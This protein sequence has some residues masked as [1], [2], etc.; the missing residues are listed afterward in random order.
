MQALE[1]ALKTA[2]AQI[3]EAEATARIRN[4]YFEI[5]VSNAPTLFGVFSEQGKSSLLSQALADRNTDSSM[6]HRGLIVQVNAIFESFIRAVCESVLAA[7]TEKASSFVEMDDTFR[8][9]YIHHSAVILTHA[10]EGAV[11]GRS[12]DFER[13]QTTLAGCILGK[14]GYEVRTEVF[15]MLMGNCTSDRLARLFRKLNLTDPFDDRVGDHAGLRKCANERSRRKAAKFARKTL[16]E[17]V[18]LRNEIAHGSLTKAVSFSELEFSA[19]FFREY[20]QAVT[21]STMLDLK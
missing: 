15:T 18:R 9:E 6:L 11:Q 10:K 21:Q 12:Y 8:S 14:E 13:L 7:R 3:E 17:Q 20:M 5:I 2:E 19:Q 1:R 4:S 16:D